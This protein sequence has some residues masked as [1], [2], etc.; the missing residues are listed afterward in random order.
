[1]NHFIM[2]GSLI[3]VG[4]T[5]LSWIIFYNWKFLW[6]QCGRLNFNRKSEQ[7]FENETKRAVRLTCPRCGA[8]EIK[9]YDRHTGSDGCGDCGC[10]D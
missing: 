9:E 10:G 6:C 1:M 7:L 4:L 2:V 5:A 8:S 3:A